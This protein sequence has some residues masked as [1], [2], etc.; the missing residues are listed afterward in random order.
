LTPEACEKE[1]EKSVIENDFD[2][3]VELTSEIT[4]KMDNM[5][6]QCTA[7]SHDRISTYTS[8]NIVH[9]NNEELVTKFKSLVSFLT[10]SGIII[11]KLNAYKRKI[12]HAEAEKLN[13]F[14]WSIQINEKDSHLVVSNNENDRSVHEKK[15]KQ[16]FKKQ[17]TNEQRIEEIGSSIDSQQITKARRVA[18]AVERDAILPVVIQSETRENIKKVLEE[19]ESKPQV[20]RKVVRPRKAEKQQTQQ[21][22]EHVAANTQRYPL[23]NK[24]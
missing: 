6:I 14:H 24:V 16:F 22:D 15:Q 3:E 4:S 17:K 2:C 18:L 20:A 23:R 9:Q 8:F 7:S 11:T 13:L 1:V 5:S 12:I 21:Q 10:N 19:A